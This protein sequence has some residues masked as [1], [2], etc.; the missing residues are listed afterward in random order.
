M[1][2]ITQ[3]PPQ[4]EIRREN[5]QQ[6]IAVTGTLEGTDLGT[7]IAAGPEGGGLHAPAAQRARRIRRHL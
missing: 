3:L 7:A 4:N 6:L 1:T 5:L 2:H